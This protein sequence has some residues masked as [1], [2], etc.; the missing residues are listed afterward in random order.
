STVASSPAASPPAPGHPPAASPGGAPAAESACESAPPDRA[1]SG[2][3][4]DADGAGGERGRQGPVATC[5]VKNTFEG[6]RHICLFSFKYNAQ[7]Q[8]R[9]CS[10]AGQRLPALSFHDYF[11]LRQSLALSPKLECSG[12]NTAHCSLNVS[13]TSDPPAS[14]SQVA[15][16]TGVDHHTWLIFKFFCRDGVSL[17]CS[18]WSQKLLGSRDPPASASQRAGTHNSH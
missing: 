13:V 11:F 12:A 16:T 18:S 6:I 4:R 5:C 2:P 3:G 8:E 1:A 7:Q 15:G 10:P 17:C 9:A 14:A